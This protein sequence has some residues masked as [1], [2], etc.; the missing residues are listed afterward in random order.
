LKTGDPLHKCLY[1]DEVTPVLA[2]PKI[3]IL[4]SMCEEPVGGVVWQVLHYL[5]GLER[6]GFEAYYVESRGNW[7][8]HPVDASVDPEFPR[9]MVGEVMRRFGFADRW[10]CRADFIRDGYTFGGF[11]PGDLPRLYEEAEAVINLTGSHV[12]DDNQLRCRRRVYLE[13]DPGV[14]QVRLTS[15]DPLAWELVLAHTHHFTFAENLD[16]PDCRLPKPRLN[17]LPTRQPVALDVWQTTVDPRCPT[18]TTIAKWRKRRNQTVVVVD[19]ETY[20]WSKDLEFKAF[21]DLPWRTRQPIE[22]ALAS[23]S[24][25]DASTLRQYGWRVVDGFSLS[26]SLEGYRRYVQTSRGE[27][28]V[29]KDLN[30]RLRT[31]WFSDRSACYLAAGKPVITQDTGFGNVLPTGEGLF[32]FKSIDDILVALDAINSDYEKHCR[33]ARQIAQ[34]YFDATRVL[35]DLLARIGLEPARATSSVFTEARP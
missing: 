9:V 5:L 11:T 25:D 6:L 14:P 29:A 2:K 34:E 33:A 4:G 27:F 16:N 7:L 10:V 26:G 13:T 21:L 35:S 23:V 24:P 28:T 15:G 18:F 20:Y 1:R 30:I 8:P 32:A 17:Y 12:L 31:G 19:G 22:L 3:V